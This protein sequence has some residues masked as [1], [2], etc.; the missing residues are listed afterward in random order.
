MSIQQL[1]FSIS[2]FSKAEGDNQVSNTLKAELCLK[3]DFPSLA[4]PQLHQGCWELPSLPAV[5]APEQADGKQDVCFKS[6]LDMKYKELQ[7][8]GKWRLSKAIILSWGTRCDTVFTN[9][10]HHWKP[11]IYKQKTCRLA[12]SQWISWITPRGNYCIITSQYTARVWYTKHVVKS[13]EKVI[14][15]I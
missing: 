13:P 11:V 12:M 14:S 8:E 1:E 6:D 2:A 10:I 7:N 4:L 3:C 15:F 5:H 9:C